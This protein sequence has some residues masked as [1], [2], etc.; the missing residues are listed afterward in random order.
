[1]IKLTLIMS[2]GMF[3]GCTQ[4]KDSKTVEQYL[5]APNEPIKVDTTLKVE[6]RKYLKNKSK[7]GDSIVIHVLVP[8][9]DVENQGVIGVTKRIADGQNPSTNLYWGAGYGIATHFKRSSKWEL[10]ARINQPESSILERLVFKHTKAPN[11]FLVADAYRGDS[12]TSCLNHYLQL[13]AGARR[14]NCAMLDSNAIHPDLIVFNGHN[15]MMDA[16]YTPPENQD[17]LREGAIV[18]ACASEPYFKEYLSEYGSYPELLTTN[19]MA[20]EAYVLHDVIEDWLLFSPEVSLRKSAGL[21]Y[22]NIQ[23]CGLRGATNLFAEGW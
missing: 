6:W 22:H 21:A 8:L 5:D 12:M 2:L 20:P 7:K 9:C 11:T 3:L 10:R 4:A 1:M 19:L 15:G 14:L 18:I 23:K 16:V 13:L 17:T